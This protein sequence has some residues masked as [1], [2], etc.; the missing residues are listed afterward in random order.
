MEYSET[1]IYKLA[2]ELD[3][4][5]RKA[6]P[7]YSSKFSKK[8]FT[9]NQHV[10]ILCLKNK[11]RQKLRETEE[12][13]LNMPTVCEAIGLRIVPDFS[14][15]C[16]AM[17]RLRAKVFM[18]LLFLTAS[19]VPCSGKASIDSTSLD[20]RH[21][22]KHY[23][24]RCKMTLGAMKVT[25]VIDTE[26][27][28]I[29]AVHAT[30]TRKSD[31]KIILPLTEKA[32]L[33]FVIKTLCGDK[34]YDDKAVRDALRSMGIRPLIPHREFNDKYKHYNEMMNQSDKHRRS[35]SE[36]DNSLIKRKYDDTLYTKAFWKQYKEV[37][38]MCCVANIERY[39]SAYA[40]IWLRISTKPIFPNTSSL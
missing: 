39:L 16:K 7:E 4:Q 31:M 38:T 19:L 35:M 10:A 30:V 32:S 2:C 1:T 5:A 26:T 29:L 20:K 25:L 22:S 15:M 21:S 9:Q 37:L 11:L 36:T 14:T 18:V 27:L 24:K 12:M 40:L 8:T 28:M 6:V 23:V 3:R 17:Q 34:G 33:Q 13:L